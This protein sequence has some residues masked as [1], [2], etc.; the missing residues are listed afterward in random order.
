MKHPMIYPLTLALV[1]CGCEATMTSS[2]ND[3]IPVSGPA[4]FDSRTSTLCSWAHETGM[5]FDGTRTEIDQVVYSRYS[6]STNQGTGRLKIYLDCEGG[7][8][9][10]S[11]NEDENRNDGWDNAHATHRMDM[12]IG[13][14]D[15]AFTF[16][17]ETDDIKTGGYRCT[18]TQSGSGL[19]R[20]VDVERDLLNPDLLHLTVHV[21]EHLLPVALQFVDPVR[22]QLY[23]PVL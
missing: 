6:D 17:G 3:T 9:M 22:E 10:L 20:L 16:G 19:S 4:S 1:L 12:P 8:S 14:T 18:E 21:F 5:A 11:W 23:D 13:V 7:E 2:S 15:G